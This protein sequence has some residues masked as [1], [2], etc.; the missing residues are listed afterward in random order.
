MTDPYLCL[1]E[2]STINGGIGHD[3]GRDGDDDNTG[4]SGDGP[5]AYHGDN[6]D[7]KYELVNVLE[8]EA[9]EIVKI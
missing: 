6:T 7:H 4:E 5:E 3:G 8:E 1:C 2:C 9:S